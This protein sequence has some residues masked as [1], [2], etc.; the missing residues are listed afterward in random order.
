MI[1]FQCDHCGF[2]VKVPSRYAGRRGRCPSCGG[3]IRI[4]E[5]A[6]DVPPPPREVTA[7]NEEPELADESE[8]SEDTHV[9]P[10]LGELPGVK[11]PAQP[12]SPQAEGEEPLP[13]E[14]PQAPAR[15]APARRRGLP[16]CLLIAAAA[17]L[18]AGLVV[19]LMAM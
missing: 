5:E 17:L 8:G 12:A 13:A 15:E 11:P 7:E 10:G 19:L 14:Q 9:L 3:V 2:G 4:P 16:V 1:R 18:V 6:S